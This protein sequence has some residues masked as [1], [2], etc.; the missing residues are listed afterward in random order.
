CFDPDAWS[1]VGFKEGYE[2]GL[3]V[4][5]WLL[6]RRDGR[7]FA[8]TGYVHDLTTEI[9]GAALKDVMAAAAELLA[10]HE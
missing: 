1:F 9:D 3:K 6:Q 2:T 7:W 5:T 8:L 10:N 4:M